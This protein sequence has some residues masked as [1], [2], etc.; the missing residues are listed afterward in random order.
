MVIRTMSAAALVMLTALSGAVPAAADAV[1]SV[2]GLTAAAVD[3]RVEAYLEAAP[4]PGVAVAVTRGSE[5]VRAAG[6]GVDSRGEPVD[7]GTPMGVASVSKAFTALV[8]ASLV[9]EGRLDLDDPVVEH[10]PEFAVDDPRGARITVGQLLTHTSGMS[11]RGFREKSEP[12]PA[13]LEGAVARL[14]DAGMVADPGAERHYHNPNY[15]VAA[16][17]VEVMEG[18]PFA[19]VLRERV[20]DPLGMADTVTVDTAAEVFAAGVAPGHVTVLGGAVSL[21]EPEGYFNGSGGMVSTADDMARWLV[22]QNTEGRTVDGGAG[23]PAG[24]VALTHAPAGGS[25]S[26]ADST[27]GWQ[28]HETGGGAPLLV[29]GGIEFTY[30]AHQALLPES[31]V[32]I[33]VMANTGLGAGD[34][35]ALLWNLVALAEGEGPTGS[36]APWLLVLD[37]VCAAAVA[38][39]AAGA[40]RGVR[41]AGVWVRGGRRWRRV[42]GA[43][44]SAAVV[45]AALFPHRLISL[46]AGGRDATWVQAL[47]TVPSVV[48]L[49]VVAAVA[50]AVVWSVRLWALAA[51]R[52]RGPVRVLSGAGAV[53]PGA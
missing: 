34:A 5:V 51:H 42:L 6:Y 12:T 7:A 10:L 31:G 39:V 50:L 28:G 45:L 33:A 46:P 17:M 38:A 4:L 8:V 21:P 48:V 35:S 2:D 22:S 16:R 26:A 14:A 19:E 40:V 27:L 24:A 9:E 49:L 30:T 43:A 52:R 23:V 1:P 11:D 32:G 20:L 41:R 29:H 47:Y 13:D 37:L 18:E 25:G 36:A 3:A 53:P 15:H 44:G